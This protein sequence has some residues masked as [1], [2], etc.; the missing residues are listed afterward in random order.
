M[1]HM[2]LKPS[3]YSEVLRKD[4]YVDNILSS[5][6]DEDSLISFYKESRQLFADGGF[7]L[8]SWSSNN[9]KLNAIANTEN[10]ADTDKTV[11]ILGLR[12]DNENDTILFEN[13]IS[14]DEI[15][16]L[17]KRDILQQSS[18]IFDPMGILSPVT[19]RAKILM[20]TLWKKK[21]GWDQ[22]LPNDLK[23]K[24]NEIVQDLREAITIQIPRYYFSNPCTKKLR[25][26]EH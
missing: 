25:G 13:N 3:S 18:K 20:Q 1:K 11:K 16:H 17:T 12:W 5:F 2:E 19:V 21:Y 26:I 10:C 15:K 7:N 6:P 4:L 9:K 8:R 23:M 22:S 24:W 14:N